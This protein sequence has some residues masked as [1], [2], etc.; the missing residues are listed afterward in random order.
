MLEHVRPDVLD[1][2]Y[3]EEG[4]VLKPGGLAFHQVPHRLVPYDSHSRTWFIHYFP[5]PLA[6][7]LYGLVGRDG[8]Y[9]QSFIFLRG[10]WAHRRRARRYIG[11]VED[12]T[13]ARFRNLRDL[14]GYDGPKRLRRALGVLARL[15]AL[16]TAFA[17]LLRNF[18]MLD[19]LAVKPGPGALA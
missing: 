2:Y 17:L 11:P 8:R 6:R 14:E 15:P 16:G 1:A 18:V 13:V 10:P 19:T 9:L 7:R 4:R 5:R 3:A 12:L